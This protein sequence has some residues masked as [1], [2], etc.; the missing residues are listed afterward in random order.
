M[1]SCRTRGCS[2]WKNSRAITLKSRIM[3]KLR[4]G[5]QQQERA[6]GN[7]LSPVALFYPSLLHVDVERIG[8]RKQE[9]EDWREQE[10]LGVRRR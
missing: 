10:G 9:M 3:K 7:G 6:F 8:S 4:N 1:T 5:I 2:F